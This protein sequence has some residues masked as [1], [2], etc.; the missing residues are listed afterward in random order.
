VASA[1]HGVDADSDNESTAS[2]GS[3]RGATLQRE[4]VTAAPTRATGVVSL[5]R[6]ASD[7]EDLLQLLDQLNPTITDLTQVIEQEV[8]KCPEVRRLR[9][10]PG[11]GVPEADRKLSGLVPLEEST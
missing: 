4:V 8:E 10:N 5:R 2:G 7:A 6:Q 1:S 9:T 11:V 3:E